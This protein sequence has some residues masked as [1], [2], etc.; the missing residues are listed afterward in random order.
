MALLPAAEA[1]LHP[2]PAFAREATYRFDIPAGTLSS[3]LSAFSA[4]TGLSVGWSGSLP[5]T[6][7]RPLHGTMSAA[8]ALCRILAGSG[9]Q[10][11]RAGAN[12]YH[13]VTWRRPARPV[14]VPPPP[15]PTPPAPPIATAVSEPIVVTG[16]KRR[17]VL[18]DVPMSV[19]VVPLGGDTD[20]RLTAGTRDLALSVE[21]L[22]LTNLGPG[23]NRQFIRGVA[24]SPFNGPSQ[25]TVAVQLDETR[26]TF[27]APDPDLRLVDMERV[28]ILKGPQG[29]L[30]GTG[31]LGGIYHM[32]SV[33][34]DLAELSGRV[35]GLA[36]AVQ[37]GG[38]GIG[39][40]AV[41]NVPL[42]TD[43][44]GLRGVAYSLR[45]GGWID[46]VR[47]DRNANRTKTDGGRLALR[48]SP[49]ADWTIDLS[50][51]FQDINPKDS[52]YVTASDDTVQRQARIPEPADN[53]FKS[54]A[55]TVEGRIGGLKLLATSSYVDHGVD[56]TLDATDASPRFGLTGVSRFV[57]DRAYSIHNHEVRLSP[58]GSSNWLAGLS[59][60]RAQSRSTATVT[61]AD[62]TVVAESL[63]R[64]VTEF[65]AFGE[66]SLPVTGDLKATAGLRLSRSI[67]EDEALERSGGRATRVSKTIA[68]PSLSLAWT[69]GADSLVYLRYARA[70]RPGG[71]APADQSAT[72]RFDAD[73]L[74]SFDLGFRHAA[75]RDL[76]F[77]ASAFYTVWSDIQSDY[78]LD[79]G[80]VSTRNAGKGRILG[81]EASVDW[82]PFAGFKLGAGASYID[83]HLVK[84]ADGI[85]L[86]D[87]RLPIT[88]DLTG[89][90]SVGYLFVIS[91]DW[92]AE[93]SAQAN[94]V[95]RARLTF[96]ETLD[97]DMGDYA[98]A[99]AGAVVTRGRLALGARIDNLFDIKGDS[100]AL[101]NPFS[102]MQA[103]Q[104]TPLRPRT[105]SLSVS[106][107]W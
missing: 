40:E 103:P 35:R 49:D 63:N 65:A 31:A 55:A 101:G 24:D 78:L 82:K 96:D 45:S 44:L 107:S 26:L 52:Q 21:G 20:G 59:Y 48:W 61:S 25:S 12:S 83:A 1:V 81:V 54:V 86:D 90:L 95:G 14:A 105:F 11:V 18:S 6:A 13:I 99:S 47:R 77:A 57:D 41:L 60:M 51:V 30:Y 8:E 68:S 79:N 36:E 23:R 32:V 87:R 73:E 27:D 53:D 3:S 19:T 74:G 4:A 10:A 9:M 106:R 71:L 72:R 5:A 62:A 70:M 91:S 94:Y 67:A 43:R 66:A 38:L 85:E 17:Q 102:I 80:L 28:E 75:G 15:R 92:A 29:P 76:S 104:Y 37:H 39:G 33:K 93:L 2:G 22:A 100:F 58:E 98:T 89:R 97:R 46:N 56:Y 42:V 50:G 7:T 64:K 16:Q 84:S 69:P 34:P 88:P